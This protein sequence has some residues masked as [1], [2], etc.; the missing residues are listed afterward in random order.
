MKRELHVQSCGVR[1]MRSVEAGGNRVR[2]TVWDKGSVRKRWRSMLDSHT[3]DL[4][5]KEGQASGAW[6]QG[7]SRGWYLSFEVKV[8][9]L[10]LSCILY[11][12][13]TESTD[14]DR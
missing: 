7:S 5:C 3:V 8:R 6:E 10:S 11:L 13:P 1:I 2:R 4:L 14:G 9:H 12:F